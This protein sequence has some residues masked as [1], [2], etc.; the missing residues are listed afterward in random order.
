MILGP[1][2]KSHCACWFFSTQSEPDLKW[3]P[4]QKKEV[5]VSQVK[6]CSELR[7]PLQ[8]TRTYWLAL[9]Q[10][11]SC[12][13]RQKLGYFMQF[14]KVAQRILILQIWKKGWLG[15]PHKTFDCK[16]SIY[17]FK[18]SLITEFNYVSFTDSGLEPRTYGPSAYE[19]QLNVDCPP[20]YFIAN[21]RSTYSGSSH[22][23]AFTLTC[24]GAPYQIE[25][26]YNC[27]YHTNYL[28]SFHQN[29]QF[30]CPGSGAITGEI[31]GDILN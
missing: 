2:Y 14:R 9:V 26:G 21:I 19:S 31:S 15:S 23:R 16:F 5:V 10:F 22:D 25:D 13:N 30:S 3:L 4:P 6:G 8:W 12:M 18:N 20:N 7:W 11:E 17:W 27:N 29:F 24:K 1:I 28:N